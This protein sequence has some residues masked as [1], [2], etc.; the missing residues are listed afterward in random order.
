MSKET[1]KKWL[2]K[3]HQEVHSL[4]G[5]TND[6]HHRGQGALEVILLLYDLK[7]YTPTYGDGLEASPVWVIHE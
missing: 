5:G 1:V 7:A 2:Q 4:S 3:L 6:G